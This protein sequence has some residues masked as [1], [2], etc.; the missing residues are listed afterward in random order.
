M[1]TSICIWLA[2]AS[3]VLYGCSG[4]AAYTSSEGRF[5]VS[6]PSGSKPSLSTSVYKDALAGSL[7]T[8]EV[9]FKN[10]DL[11]FIISYWDYPDAFFKE[12]DVRKNLNGIVSQITGSLKNG[13]KFKDGSLFTIKEITMDG[14]PG[15]DSSVSYGVKDDQTYTWITKARYYLVGQRMYG[16]WADGLIEH[17]AIIDSF[18]NSFKLAPK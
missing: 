12:S 17:V 14:L 13:D 10:A 4:Q 8:Y 18:M 11:R 15:I 1:K 2:I 3:L 9:Q 16:L 7:T 6:T 5:S